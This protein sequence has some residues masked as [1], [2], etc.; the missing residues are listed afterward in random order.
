VSLDR[1]GLAI[2]SDSTIGGSSPRV[3]TQDRALVNC[4]L[5]LHHGLV[6]AESLSDLVL[7]AS[8]AN[9]MMSHLW[10]ASTLIVCVADGNDLVGWVASVRNTVIVLCARLSRLKY[11]MR[12]VRPQMRIGVRTACRRDNSL[13]RVEAGTGGYQGAYLDI[14]CRIGRESHTFSNDLARMRVVLVEG[15][16]KRTM[17][18]IN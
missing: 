9:V 5:I 17:N 15:H 10:V 4:G 6:L 14:C 12:I 1:D 18:Y 8:G 7:I 13:S 11:V 2:F 3:R 16:Y